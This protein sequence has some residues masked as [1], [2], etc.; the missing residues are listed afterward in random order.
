MV[1]D[2]LLENAP[3]VKELTNRQKIVGSFYGYLWCDFP[4]LSVVY[5][6]HLALAKLRDI[7]RAAGCHVYSD[8]HD[9]VY[10]DE[11]F[12]CIY[13]PAGGVRTIFLHKKCRVLD[14]LENRV[15]AEAAEQ[16]RLTMAAN[17]SLL[18]SLEPE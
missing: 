7:A 1:A 3:W 18:M 13:A 10:A 15:I 11:N 4:N 5:S 12:L 2:V 9:V 17:Q 16:F 8:A 6:G 14:L